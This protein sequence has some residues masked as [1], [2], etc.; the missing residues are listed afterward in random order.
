MLKSLLKDPYLNTPCVAA[1]NSWIGTL[2]FYGF[3]PLD[4]ALVMIPLRIR[5]WQI[6]AKTKKLEKKSSDDH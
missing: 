3:S 4:P 6:K 1:M 5:L 2:N